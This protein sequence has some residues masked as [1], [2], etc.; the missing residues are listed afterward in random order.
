MKFEDHPSVKAITARSA[1]VP[2]RIS[3]GDR[4][5]LRAED[6]RALAL[7]SGADDVGFVPIEHPE[8]APDRARLESALPGV[9]AVIAVLCRMQPENVR[10][11]ERAIANQAFHTTG[12]HVDEVCRA[13]VLALDEQGVRALNPS[14]A[15]PMNVSSIGDERP[16]VLSYK[17]LAEVAGLGRMGLHRSVIHPKFGSFVLLGGVLVDRAIDAYSTELSYNPCVDCRLC[18]AACP[19]G[20]IHPDGHFNA[21][22]CT[23][24]NYREFMGGFVDWV[25]T[26][27][28]AGS[29]SD[30]RAQVRDSETLSLWQSLAYGPNYKAAYC[31][32]V[33]PAGESVLGA[34]IE[35]RAQHTQRV[36]RPLQQKRE[37]VYVTRG[38]PAEAHVRSRFPHKE[39]R[40]VRSGVRPQSVRG[41]L[42]S[43]P[44]LFQREHSEGLSA[45]YHFSFTGPQAR[46]ATVTIR[47]RSLRV[48]AGLVGTPDVHVNADGSSWIKFLGGDLP[49]WKMLLTR[50]LRLS[51][52]VNGARLLARFGRCFPR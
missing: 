28:G 5:R 44:W 23:T 48:D 35:A 22:A 36:V 3:A 38:S 30:Y 20:A 12:L 49:L 51:P 31:L 19:V 13:M 8:L 50:R 46:E 39:V 40:V 47:E 21:P 4:P 45:V 27:A 37:P 6:L 33:C 11:P 1:S 2:L 7:A 42:E 14:M 9:R 41:F 29:A 10:S 34:L 43:I 18:V 52:R 24:H 17:P 15:F 32:S 26:L 25:E 16:W